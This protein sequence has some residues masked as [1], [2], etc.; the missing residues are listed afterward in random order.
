[1]GSIIVN[2]SGGS[3]GCGSRVADVVAHEYSMV[4]VAVAV[5]RAVMTNVSSGDR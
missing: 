1:M 5:N 4:V 2:R 3:S